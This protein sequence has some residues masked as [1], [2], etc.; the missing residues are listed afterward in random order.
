[1][2]KDKDNSCYFQVEGT[3]GTYPCH[4]VGFGMTLIKRE[5]FETLPRPFFKGNEKD[6]KEDNYFCDKLLSLGI[7]PYGCFD[8]TLPHC[9]ITE[10]NVLEK[11][12]FGAKEFVSK[13][14]SRKSM[15]SYVRCRRAIGNLSEYDEEVLNRIE[16]VLTK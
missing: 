3:K 8:H 14:N 1:M 11:R 9:G 13:S 6:E 2:I 16:R 12:K 15:E 10:D 7:Y 5:I 4:F